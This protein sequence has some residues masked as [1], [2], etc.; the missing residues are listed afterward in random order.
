[1]KGLNE[2]LNEENHYLFEN[3]HLT[4]MYDNS[5]NR[6]NPIKKIKITRA[7]QE[8]G[9]LKNKTFD[10]FGITWKFSAPKK[11]GNILTIKISNINDKED[12]IDVIIRTGK[13]HLAEI[14]LYYRGR[15]FNSYNDANEADFRNNQ[16]NVDGY[17]L[18]ELERETGEYYSN[19]DDIKPLAFAISR[20]FKRDED[21]IFKSI[22]SI[23]NE[24]PKKV[25][26]SD[27]KY[28]QQKVENARTRIESYKMSIQKMDE[29][30]QGKGWTGGSL[31]ARDFDRYNKM[32]ARHHIE[33]KRRENAEDKKKIYQKYLDDEKKALI[34][35]EQELKKLL[36]SQ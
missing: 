20:W 29:I 28:A 22:T 15:S 30:I 25:L 8:W 19:F 24:T 26:K 10:A 9:K 35:A 3:T 14:E 21:S 33:I 27:I 36:D 31:S 6:I 7:K 2:F 4:K 11:S 18:K 13:K 32:G 16:D 34:K 5:G 1:M 23:A 17:Y 12:Y